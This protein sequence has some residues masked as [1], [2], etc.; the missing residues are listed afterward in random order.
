[1]AQHSFMTCALVSARDKRVRKPGIASSLSSVPPVCPSPRPDI[2]GT[3]TPQ[4]APP[5][6]LPAP[7]PPPPRPAPPPAPPR[8][9]GGAA[10]ARAPARPP[11]PAAVCG[12]LADRAPPPPRARDAA[13]KKTPASLH[14]H[15]R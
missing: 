15:T 8:G 12:V 4:A 1:M 11:P 10:G 3:A 9:P 5:A 13:P 7:P 14:R 6:A 2:I